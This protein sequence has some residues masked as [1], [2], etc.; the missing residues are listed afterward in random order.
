MRVLEPMV[1]HCGRVAK[2][3]KSAV[4]IMLQVTYWQIQVVRFLLERGLASGFRN[5]DL[6]GHDLI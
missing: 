6:F 5:L 3:D 1:L 2:F 4:T